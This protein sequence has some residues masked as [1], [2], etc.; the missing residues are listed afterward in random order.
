MHAEVFENSGAAVMWHE[1]DTVT[2][3]DVKIWRESD[4]VADVK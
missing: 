1:S 4:I 2:V 3:V